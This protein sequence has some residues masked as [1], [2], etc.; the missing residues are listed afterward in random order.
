M[1]GGF[2]R[3]GY[4]PWAGC[5]CGETWP[6]ACWIRRAV[7]AFTASADTA[8]SLAAEPASPVGWSGLELGDAAISRPRGPFCRSMGQS[9]TEEL[10]SREGDARAGLDEK[11]RKLK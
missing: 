1:G 6:A 4:V 11:R 5:G 7:T 3:W 10:P 8:C 9:K 2:E